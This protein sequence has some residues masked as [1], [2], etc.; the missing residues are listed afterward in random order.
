[1]HALPAGEN[2]KSKR[3]ESRCGESIELKW[4]YFSWGRKTLYSLSYRIAWRKGEWGQTRFCSG[5]IKLIH[6]YLGNVA[7]KE[8]I[9]GGAIIE[10]DV[11]KLFQW[12]TCWSWWVF[13]DSRWRFY[14]VEP[15]FSYEVYC[16]LPQCAGLFCFPDKV[17]YSQVTIGLA[18]SYKMEPEGKKSA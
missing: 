11:L 8:K 16:I 3:L 7:K 15:N 6:N 9:D 14:F 18:C 12:Y 2:E 4:N 17:Y 5:D 13:S 10:Y 1:M